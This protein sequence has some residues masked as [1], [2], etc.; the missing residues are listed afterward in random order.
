[1]KGRRCTALFGSRV[2]G[3]AVSGDF[4]TEAI[5]APSLGKHFHQLRRAL[6]GSRYRVE[7][8]RDLA[9]ELKTDPD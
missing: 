6:S 1:M 8:H 4:L 3:G 9:Y 5:G 7:R 2:S